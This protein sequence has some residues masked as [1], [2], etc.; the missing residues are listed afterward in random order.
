MILSVIILMVFSSLNNDNV[1][2]N[3]LRWKNRVVIFFQGQGQ[4]ETKDIDSLKSELEERK[5]VFLSIGDTFTTNSEYKFSQKFIR[6]LKEK[7]ALKNSD[8]N[9]LL[10]GLDGGVK[11]KSEDS[12][13]WDLVFRTVD[14]M[15]MRQSE[16]KK[17]D[18]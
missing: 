18:G 9:W 12:L 10:I 5:I 11:L 1:T 8:G 17:K 2:L 6:S 16:I 7:Y 15:P 13:D 3:D 14:A 4:K